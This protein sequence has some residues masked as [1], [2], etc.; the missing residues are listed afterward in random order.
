M[1]LVAGPRDYV[2]AAAGCPDSSIIRTDYNPRKPDA[3]EVHLQ[4]LFVIFQ[5]T[6]VGGPWS[7]TKLK[8]AC[9]AAMLPTIA[10]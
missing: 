4:K 1:G 2:F 7:I 9:G 6:Y 8:W 5:M 3:D 10:N